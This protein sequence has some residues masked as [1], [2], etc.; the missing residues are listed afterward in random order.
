MHTIT[1]QQYKDKP[2]DYKSVW[3]SDHFRGTNFN[4]RRTLMTY[5]NGTRLLIEGESLKIVE[6][7]E[8]NTNPLPKH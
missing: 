8:E 7:D 1:E 5:L 3:S 2:K 6:T 4:G